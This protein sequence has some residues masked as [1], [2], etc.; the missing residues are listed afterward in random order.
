MGAA[1]EISTLDVREPLIP[2]EE[3]YNEPLNETVGMI[4]SMQRWLVIMQ[5]MVQL[6]TLILIRTLLYDVHMLSFILPVRYWCWCWGT[7]NMHLG[8]SD[9]KSFKQNNKNNK[10]N[11]VLVIFWKSDNLSRFSS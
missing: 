8:F 4:Y 5:I 10:K 7:S 11:N 2:M 1:L 3:F 9:C 6:F